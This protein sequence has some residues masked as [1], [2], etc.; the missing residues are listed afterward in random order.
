MSISPLPLT[1]HKYKT[2]TSSHIFLFAPRKL[3]LIASSQRTSTCCEALSLQAKCAT[4][5]S[6]P[7]KEIDVLI[8]AYGF[9]V[10][11]TF[12][13]SLFKVLHQFVCVHHVSCRYSSGFFFMVSSPFHQV[14][15]CNFIFLFF[16]LGF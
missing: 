1:N 13:P 4:S 8:N 12:S 7:L 6:P 10:I 2:R 5:V 9:F 16:H 3:D 14:V 11:G 15:L